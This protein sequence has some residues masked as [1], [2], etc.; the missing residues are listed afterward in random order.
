MLLAPGLLAA[1]P[2]ATTAGLSRH[3]LP[4]P[5]HPVVVAWPTGGG[6][7][8]PVRLVAGPMGRVLGV[9]E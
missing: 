8:T 3:R 2:R 9:V 7:D 1:T 5:S 6:V 4:D